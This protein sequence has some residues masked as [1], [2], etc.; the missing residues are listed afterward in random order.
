MMSRRQTES[1]GTV[2]AVAKRACRA[3]S[4]PE[5]RPARV[6]RYMRGGANVAALGVTANGAFTWFAW[7]TGSEDL[8]AL[9]LRLFFE[10]AAVLVVLSFVPRSRVRGYLGLSLASVFTIAVV[11]QGLVSAPAVFWLTLAVLVA[12]LFVGGAADLV[13]SPARG[14]SSVATASSPDHSGQGGSVLEAAEPHE[15]RAVSEQG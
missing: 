5:E 10:L 8:Q 14:V 9:A 15:S 13:E 7:P 4:I 2:R 3:W 12:R 1:P 11:A 6:A